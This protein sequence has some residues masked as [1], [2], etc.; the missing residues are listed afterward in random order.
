MYGEVETFLR[1]VEV[2]EGM[3]TVIYYWE[4]KVAEVNR[5]IYV[6]ATEQTSKQSIPWQLSSKYSIEEA[7]I[8]LAEVCDQKI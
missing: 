6:S 7:V 8:E 5:K 2:Q 4:I 3:K 1:P